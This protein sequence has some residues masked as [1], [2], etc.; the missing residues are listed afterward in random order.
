MIPRLNGDELSSRFDYYAALT[1]KGV[2]GF[3]IFGGEIDVVRDG[4]REL[5]RISERPLIIASDLEQGLGQHV[6]GGTLFPPA[7]AIASAVR[8]AGV[9]SASSLLTKLYSAFAQEALYAGINTIFAPVLDINT[10]PKN[11]IIATRSFGEDPETVSYLG[12]EMI[13][14]IQGNNVIACGKHFPGHGDTD[15]DS[16][17]SLPVLNRGLF[18]LEN[19]ELIPFRRAIDCGVKMIMLGH[20]SVPAIDPSGIPVSLS[21]MAVSYLRN[22]MGFKGIVITDAMNMG[23]IGK[24]TE[25]EASVMALKAGVDIILHPKDPDNIAA[26][27]RQNN[28][29]M[30]S[31]NL[32]I[33]TPPNDLKPGFDDNRRLSEEM[34]R[35]AIRTEGAAHIKNPFIIIITDDEDEDGRYFIAALRKKHPDIKHCSILPG[36]DI[37]WQTIPPGHDL[38][39]SIFSNVRAWKGDT[40]R[41]VMSA[42][43]RLKDRAKIFAAFGN[44]YLL[45]EGSG[46]MRIYAYW[47]SK[48]AQEAAAEKI[49]ILRS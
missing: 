48:E 23:G 14:I 46:D 29:S 26:Y 24:F 8:K 16:H 43:S 10:N 13:D 34:T 39:I 20:L 30:E 37:P 36:V 45:N 38:L 12:C 31:L 17:I 49:M 35:M 47:A 28:L 6:R 15:I 25:E 1:R 32:N 27:L 42:I 22:I 2:A 7:M 5:Q 41:W 3:I 11:P 40:K 18:D 9:G 4:L 33:S 19:N 21:A 44:P